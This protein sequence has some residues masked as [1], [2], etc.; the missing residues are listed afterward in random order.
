LSNKVV[1]SIT[2]KHQRDET[3]PLLYV[4]K[5]FD[6]CHATTQSISTLH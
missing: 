1:L 6:Y 2:A 5:T 3:A 4:T